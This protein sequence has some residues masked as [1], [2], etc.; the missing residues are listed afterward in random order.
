MKER[1]IG[2]DIGID[3]VGA[4][5][6]TLNNG[7]CCE[8][9]EPS[10][11]TFSQS[12]SPKTGMTKSTQ[13]GQKRRMRR[14]VDR[15]KLRLSDARELFKN[16]LGVDFAELMKTNKNIVSPAE[17]KVKG[18]TEKLTK[19]E[20]VNRPLQLSQIQRIQVEPQSR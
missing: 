1:A 6:V 16:R 2:L 20:L 3:S 7:I 9:I 8:I 12:E 11:Y 4:C 15:K 10:S 13:R 5:V 14:Q 17:L 19:E 18:L